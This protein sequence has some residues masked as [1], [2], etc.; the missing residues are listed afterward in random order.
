MNK[1]II[2][3]LVILAVV[4]MIAALII[5][6]GKFTITGNVDNGINETNKS[7]ETPDYNNSECQVLKDGSRICKIGQIVVN[8]GGVVE[9]NYDMKESNK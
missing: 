5:N 9:T 1:K 4:I 3:A 8:S 6:H 7:N 2:D